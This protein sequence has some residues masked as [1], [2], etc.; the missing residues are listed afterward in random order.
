MAKYTTKS[1]WYDLK[2]PTETAKKFW[3]AVKPYLP[4]IIAT[5]CIFGIAIVGLKVR[6]AKK[7]GLPLTSLKR[8]KLNYNP[9]NRVRRGGL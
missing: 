7:L 9:I 2:H 5:A 8:V 3:S 6:K 4:L 1:F